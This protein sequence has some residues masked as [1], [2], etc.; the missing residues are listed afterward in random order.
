[1]VFDGYEDVSGGGRHNHLGRR[2]A[3]IGSVELDRAIDRI[4]QDARE[5]LPDVLASFGAGG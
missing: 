5:A 3:P 1:M 4:V 2:A